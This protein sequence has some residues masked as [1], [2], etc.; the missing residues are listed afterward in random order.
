MGRRLRQKR[1]VHLKIRDL[2]LLADPSNG[3]AGPDL[4]LAPEVA[5]LLEAEIVDEAA[6]PSD[7]LEGARLFERWVEPD[8]CCLELCHRLD[9]NWSD[10]IVEAKNDIC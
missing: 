3:A 6:T 5:A 9:Y 2:A 10:I 8:P 4:V 7:A 1:G